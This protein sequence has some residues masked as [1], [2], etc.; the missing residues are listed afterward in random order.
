MDIADKNKPAVAKILVYLS[1]VC[2]ILAIIGA[3]G[4]DLYLASTQW[5][6]IAILL[7]VWGTYMLVEGYLRSNR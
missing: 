3:T 6:L 2:V 1:V 5:L 7:A 4:N